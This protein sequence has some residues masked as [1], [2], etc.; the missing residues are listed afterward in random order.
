MFD[1]PILAAY[2]YSGGGFTLN[3]GLKPL[4]RQGSL[5]QVGDRAAFEPRQNAKTPAI[6]AFGDFR[7]LTSS[8]VFEHFLW[9]LSPVPQLGRRHSNA[10]H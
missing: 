1:A 9:E 5:D 7:I 6:L 2:Q 4:S 10:C 8:H 3:K